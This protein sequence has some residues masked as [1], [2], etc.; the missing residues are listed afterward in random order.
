M[1]C[2]G[3]SNTF[4]FFKKKTKVLWGIGHSRSEIENVQGEPRTSYSARKQGNY[5]RT[6][7]LCQGLRNRHGF[8]ANG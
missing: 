1:F 3:F 8:I 2:R 4:F 5:K 6:P 7:A